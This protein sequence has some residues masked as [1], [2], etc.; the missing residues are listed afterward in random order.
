ME[1]KSK[2]RDNI[3][4]RLNVA[5]REIHFKSVIGILGLT[6]DFE[7]SIQSTFRD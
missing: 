6:L 3:K 4:E 7:S 5:N 2:L 1:K